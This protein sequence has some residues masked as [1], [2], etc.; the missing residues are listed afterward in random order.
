MANMTITDVLSRL[1]AESV[2]VTR[3]MIYVAIE[4]RVVSPTKSTGG[5]YLFDDAD[6]ANMRAYCTRKRGAG[7][8]PKALATAN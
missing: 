2:I 1:T 8:P 5:I 4:R 6:L 3:D 7:R